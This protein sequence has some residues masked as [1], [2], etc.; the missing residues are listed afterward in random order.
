M[1]RYNNRFALVALLF[2][3][4]VGLAV[5]VAVARASERGQV[6][7]SGVKQLTSSSS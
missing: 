7:S 1:P 5:G 2:V 3:S 6:P 4:V